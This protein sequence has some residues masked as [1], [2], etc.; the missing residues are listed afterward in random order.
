MY[1][2]LEHDQNAHPPSETLHRLAITPQT[3]MMR[4]LLAATIFLHYSVTIS[5]TQ[6]RNAVPLTK[7][8][9]KYLKPSKS[10]LTILVRAPFFQGRVSAAANKLTNMS[11]EMKVKLRDNTTS[12][13]FFL[14][15]R[16]WTNYSVVFGCPAIL[17]HERWCSI[18]ICDGRDFLP[19]DNCHKSQYSGVIKTYG[20]DDSAESGEEISAHC[21]SNTGHETATK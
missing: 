10:C 16:F 13:G 21:H 9:S 3:S 6:E 11:K 20:S 2:Y 4:F 18:C 19:H 17:C 1:P 7:E 14:M 8:M 15:N 5:L 12:T